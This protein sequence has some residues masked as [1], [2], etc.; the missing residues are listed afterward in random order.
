MRFRRLIIALTLTVA[1]I[2][3]Y[4]LRFTQLAR[5]VEQSAAQAA[6][7]ERGNLDFEKKQAI[8]DRQWKEP[9][10][11][12]LGIAYTY[13]QI[14][15]KE[16]ALGLDLQGG[17]HL[18][19]AIDPVSMLKTLAGTHSKDSTF[20]AILSTAQQQHAQTPQ[21][22]FLDLFL[23]AYEAKQPA[24]P[25]RYL[26]ATPEVSDQLASGATN[27]QVVDVLR[28]H[29]VQKA[30][31]TLPILRRRLDSLGTSGVHLYHQPQTALIEIE[32]PGASSRQ[33]I[34]QLLQ[35][36][37][38]LMFYEVAPSKEHCDTFLQ[39]VDKHRKAQGQA[40][41]TP[42]LE[43]SQDGFFFCKK[44]H[45]AQ[46]KKLFTQE[47]IS[48]LLPRGIGLAIAAQPLKQ[49]SNL[50]P[51]Y[52]IKQTW[53]GQGLL[54][55]NVLTKA[56]W[57][58]QQGKYQVTMNMTP[59]GA[60]QWRKITEEH[61]GKL[62]AITL[63][64]GQGLPE[65]Y[66]A[67]MI[68][69][70]IPNGISS[71]NGDFTQEQVEDLANILNSGPLPAKLNIVAEAIIGPTLGAKAQ[72]Q[73]IQSVLIGLL[74]IILLTLAYYAMAGLAANLALGVNMLFILGTLAQLGAAL[75]LPGIAGIILTIGMAVD[76]NVLIFERVR[77]ELKKGLYVTTAIANGYQKA[78]SSIIDS[79]LTSLLTGM[80]LY[81]M[82]AGPVKGFATTLMIG[83]VSSFFTAV[84]VNRLLLQ[85]LARL[86]G[87]A[88][89]SFS[90]PFTNNL[91]TGF[92]LNFL[93]LRKWAYLFSCLFI[94]TGLGLT[95]QQGGLHW[96]V[97]FKGG[98]TY[99]VAFAQPPS[100]QG[101]KKQLT[102]AFDQ[103]STEVKTYGGNNVLKITTSYKMDSA[104]LQDDDQV[105]DLLA[106][107]I[108]SCTQ[109][110]YLPNAQHLPPDS[111]TIASASKVG[112]S[113][114][115]DVKN[116][117]KWAI[118]L[119]LLIIFLYILVR[120]RRWQ[121]GLS[122]I[123]ALVHDTL[124]IFAAFAIM[125]ALGTLYDID[126]IFIASVLTVIGYS[127]NDTVVVFDR[128]R[129]K[130]QLSGTHQL[131][132]L[133]NASINETMSRTLITSLTTLT[134]VL[135]LYLL[136]GEALQGFSFA[137]LVG[138]VLGTYSSI[139]IAAPLAHDLSRT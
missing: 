115:E 54:E 84:F 109:S 108:A 124:T 13:E 125:R 75:T 127:I 139:F 123:I 112:P 30:Q 101:I 1:A 62:V 41:L 39:A 82:G 97:D 91:L 21:K 111:F 45:L 26:F 69:S 57:E 98:R 50:V 95:Y 68:Q 43:V 129:E 64:N 65:V 114:A 20:L 55:G 27:Q 106:R 9:V 5:S 104:T 37:A 32:F 34:Q 53:D 24:A 8:L 33:R 71:I 17:S 131:S 130:T 138:V 12:L 42:W 74:L 89:I 87:P 86:L 40:P 137:M 49:D 100:M 119:A 121:F 122:A 73:G 25:L 78:Y 77:E 110:T 105:Q 67:P 66:C 19:L 46:V 132:K 81:H 103:Q 18:T 79:N 94:G 136:G 96:G 38:K 16:L 23:Q 6:T 134:A 29:M 3:V 47:A 35:N 63:D 70:V 88:R 56:T 60:K 2:S 126:Q 15:E 85:L 113:V 116:A 99:I 28:K 72:Q 36:T 120:F 61:I 10:A 93:R 22:D 51:C 14:K 90:F 59:A 83:V 7:D 58:M 11:R 4:A 31:E 135:S 133:V 102:Q 117:S 48:L 92:N 44:P 128:I 76:A 80:V 107:E 118:L 52:F